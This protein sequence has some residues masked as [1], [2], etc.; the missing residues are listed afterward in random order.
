MQE[1]AHGMTSMRI[2]RILA[3]TATGKGL[4]AARESGT[5]RY[6]GEVVIVSY[7]AMYYVLRYINRGTRVYF[8]TILCIPGRICFLSLLY[9]FLPF[10]FLPIMNQI[11]EA[12][13][14]H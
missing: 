13:E 3:A 1:K 9:L 7:F 14:R 12:E 6:S 8:V 2:T 5:D 4:F 11:F 10:L